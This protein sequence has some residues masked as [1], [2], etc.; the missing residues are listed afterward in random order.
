MIF[1]YAGKYDGDESKL[2]SKEHPPGAVPFK[3]PEDIK[4]LSIIAN[5]G[6]IIVIIILA[7]PFGMIG[8]KY[9]LGKPVYVTVG[10]ICAMLA[11]IPHEFLHAICFKEDVYLYT[12]LRHGLLF[13]VGTEDMS[14]TRFILMSLFP[15]I[16]LGLIPYIAFMIHPPLVGFGFF[17][18]LNLGMGFGDYIN[19]YNAAR[20]M[21]RKAKTYLCGMHSFWYLQDRD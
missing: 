9:M 18:L 20:Q 10:C 14:K 5:V 11:L 19:V 3:E 15:S 6:C 4:K 7:V 1:H 2:P 13:V 16:V 8:G 21:P 12:D 17:G